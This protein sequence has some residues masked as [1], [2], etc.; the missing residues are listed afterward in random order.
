MTT[1]FAMNCLVARPIQLVNMKWAIRLLLGQQH[2]LYECKIGRINSYKLQ[3]KFILQHLKYVMSLYRYKR[4][5][6][7]L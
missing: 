5:S 7:R 2:I 4:A 1:I 3:N 6:K